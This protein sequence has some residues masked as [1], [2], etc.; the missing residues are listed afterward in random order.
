MMM[1]NLFNAD[2][3]VFYGLVELIF[4]EVAPRKFLLFLSKKYLNFYLYLEVLLTYK[5]IIFNFMKCLRNTA[6]KSLKRAPVA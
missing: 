1:L 4:W 2:I 5:E 3:T 6:D